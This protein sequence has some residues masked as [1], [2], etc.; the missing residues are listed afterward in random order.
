MRYAC[1]ILMSFAC[2]G[3]AQTRTSISGQVIND[4]QG[5]PNFYSVPSYGYVQRIYDRGTWAYHINGVQLDLNFFGSLKTITVASTFDLGKIG[6]VGR[7]ETPQKFASIWQAFRDSHSLNE[8]GHFVYDASAKTP[9]NRLTLHEFAHFVSESHPSIELN[10]IEKCN[11][12]DGRRM[13]TGI[14]AFGAVG[15]VPCEECNAYGSKA[16]KETVALVFN[17]K[18]PERPKLDDLI[19]EGLIA[20]TKPEPAPAIVIEQPKLEPKMAEPAAAPKEFTPEERFQATKSKAQAGD[21]QAQYDI[22]L[23]Y[24]QEYEK[25]TPLDYFESYSWIHKAALKNHPLAQRQLARMYETGRGTER[26]LEQAIKWYR[27]SALLGCKQ[28]QRWMGQLY[29]QTFNGSSLYREFVSQDASNLTESYAWFSLGAE[30]TIENADRA[31]SSNGKLSRR[32]Q[33]VEFSAQSISENE[34]DIVVAKSGFTKTV[35]DAAK[36]RF[37]VLKV[38]SEDYIKSNPIK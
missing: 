15:E 33:G 2:L 27:S 35:S 23:Y 36:A 29:Y 1:L 16:K 18:L 30:R 24:S 31:N 4:D 28:G 14:N 11:R 37:A 26:N 19:K 6:Q 38:E 9:A 7:V 22:G 21:A 25:V 13:R 34:R 12:C 17:G 32:D 5:R 20:K 10:F 3:S 8:N